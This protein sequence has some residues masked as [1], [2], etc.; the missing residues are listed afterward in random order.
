MVKALEAD[1]LLVSALSDL[2]GDDLGDLADRLFSISLGDDDRDDDFTLANGC[3]DTE[4]LDSSIAV[5]ADL[6]SS[7]FASSKYCSFDGD[8]LALRLGLL[9]VPSGRTSLTLGGVGIFPSRGLTYFVNSRLSLMEIGLETTEI[10]SELSDGD[11]F[12]V[13]SIGSFSSLGDAGVLSLGETVRTLILG[14]LNDGIDVDFFNGAGGDD[15]GT[16]GGVGSG[17][18]FL[19]TIVGK[20]SLNSSTGRKRS[21]LISNEIHFSNTSSTLCNQVTNS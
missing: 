19:M 4:G 3:G 2:V 16:G 15:D 5:S 12:N 11:F 7:R 21:L 6:I 13:D 20:V 18:A 17:F 8:A 1:L 9:T 10:L 14:G